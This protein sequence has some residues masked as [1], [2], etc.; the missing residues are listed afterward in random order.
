MAKNCSVC[1]APIPDDSRSGKCLDC[2]RKEIKKIFDE[3]PEAKAAFKETIEEL[4]K[5]ENIMKMANDAVKF[6]NALQT[7][8]KK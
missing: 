6:M 4:R 5:P 8:R 7:A 2:C 1:N 3:N